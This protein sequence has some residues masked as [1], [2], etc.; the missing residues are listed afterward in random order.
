MGDSS[1]YVSARASLLL[2]RKSLFTPCRQEGGERGAPGQEQSLVSLSVI[3][4]GG[5]AGRQAG[6]QAGREAGRQAG[7]RVGMQAEGSCP[8]TLPSHPGSL[9]PPPPPPTSSLSSCGP[10][11][12][13]PPAPLLSTSCPP[14]PLPGSHPVVHI[15]HGGC[16]NA[17]QVREG[18]VHIASW[19]EH[20]AAQQGIHLQQHRVRGGKG[21]TG[22]GVG[23]ASQGGMSCGCH[24]GGGRAGGRAGR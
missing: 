24:R 22:W 8:L 20:F 13:A 7:R 18:V 19:H 6:G 9:L 21:I 11:H 2:T 14:P 15:M 1:L 23:R 4:A 5:Q 12:G 3:Q 16:N 10:H 17:G